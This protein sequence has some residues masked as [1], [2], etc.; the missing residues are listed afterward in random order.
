[1][2]GSHPDWLKDIANAD[3]LE[4]ELRQA[5]ADAQQVH[6][7]GDTLP[8][9]PGPFGSYDPEGLIC[10]RV[11]ELNREI[12]DAQNRM[13]AER[14]ASYM[15]A[16]YD[17]FSLTMEHR[18]LSRFAQ[19]TSRTLHDLTAADAISKAAIVLRQEIEQPGGDPQ[20]K[21][22]QLAMIEEIVELFRKEYAAPTPDDAPGPSSA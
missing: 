11:A 20:E 13:K 4:E 7:A 19:E 3:E 15:Q 8:L 1:M 17:S 12:I 10:K 9:D 21:E 18:L 22:E 16:A 14:G 2:E 6:G 5:E